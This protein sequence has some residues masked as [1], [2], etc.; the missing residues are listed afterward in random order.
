MVMCYVVGD[1]I[2]MR[3][4]MPGLTSICTQ[5]FEVV[6]MSFYSQISVAAQV[7]MATLSFS[8]FEARENAK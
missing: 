8:V 6:G 5:I 3:M 1:P 2:G 7:S 4:S